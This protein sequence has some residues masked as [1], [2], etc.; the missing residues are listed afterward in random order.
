MPLYKLAGASLLRTRLQPMTVMHLRV[1]IRLSLVATIWTLGV[2]GGA[3]H[4]G[5][6]AG[7][8]IER[9]SDSEWRCSYCRRGTYQP[10]DDTFA[11]CVEPGEGYYAYEYS[12]RVNGYNIGMK[13]QEKCGTGRWTDDGIVCHWCAAGMSTQHAVGVSAPVY[14]GKPGIKWPALAEADCRACPRGTYSQLTREYAANGGYRSVERICMDCPAG[15]HQD[16]YG[17]SGD[18]SCKSTT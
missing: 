16:S 9:I 6:A 13:T 5:C 12:A 2:T 8:N 7:T 14:P 11:Q 18:S 3:Q 4:T 10:L 15:T 1:L 17:Q